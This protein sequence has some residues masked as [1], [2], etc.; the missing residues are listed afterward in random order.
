MSHSFVNEFN[1]CD[2]KITWPFLN[3]NKFILCKAEDKHSLHS[4]NRLFSQM[5]TPLP[6]IAPF[7][8]DSREDL[9]STYTIINYVRLDFLQFCLVK[10]KFNTFIVIMNVSSVSPPFTCSLGCVFSLLLFTVFLLDRLS[11]LYFILSFDLKAIPSIVRQ[12]TDGGLRRQLP[13]LK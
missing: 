9:I 12:C 7:L 10:G 5:H 3:L 6:H 2:H 11:F 13:E 4:R 1:W 8:D